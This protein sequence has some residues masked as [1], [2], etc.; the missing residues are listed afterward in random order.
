M[1]L[2]TLDADNHFSTMPTSTIGLC[3]SS[4]GAFRGPLPLASALCG[5]LWLVGFSVNACVIIRL[6]FRPKPS[7]VVAIRLTSHIA[8]VANSPINDF[9]LSLP[10]SCPWQR[11]FHVFGSLTLEHL[12]STS[13]TFSCLTRIAIFVWILILFES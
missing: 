4:L 3:T 1:I 6:S 12:R 7:R 9:P 10:C 13:R 8:V 2:Q 11:R 5:F